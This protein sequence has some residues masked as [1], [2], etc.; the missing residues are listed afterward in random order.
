[1]N[2][3][4]KSCQLAGVDEHGLRLGDGLT[5]CDYVFVTP[6]HQYSAIAESLIRDGVKDLARLVDFTT[7]TKPRVREAR[8]N[9]TRQQ[10]RIANSRSLSPR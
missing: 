5:K 2:G 10:R 6:S 9:V 3:Y 4:W 1:M 8:G 7:R